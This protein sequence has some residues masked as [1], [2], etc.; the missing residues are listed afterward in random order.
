MAIDL[1]CSCSTAYQNNAD[2]FPH[3]LNFSSEQNNFLNEIAS[4]GKLITGQDEI[5]IIQ[6][7]LYGN[8]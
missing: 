4:I 7:F 2:Y 6:N 1:P 5:K 3:C 8:K